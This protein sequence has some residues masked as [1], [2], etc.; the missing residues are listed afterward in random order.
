MNVGHQI[1]RLNHVGK[2]E[3]VRVHHDGVL[4]RNQLLHKLPGRTSFAKQDAIQINVHEIG[5]ERFY[6][7]AAS[8]R[9]K[10]IRTGTPDV[11]KIQPA[12]ESENHGFGHDLAGIVVD[13]ITQRRSH[14]MGSQQ[15]LV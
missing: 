5:E 1:M 10:E 6:L 4:F 15:M 7:C 2:V 8:H 11:G 14:A 3:H 12:P 13:E 9:Q